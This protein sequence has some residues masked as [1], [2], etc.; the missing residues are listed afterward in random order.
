MFPAIARSLLTS[1]L[2]VGLLVIKSRY[3][4]LYIPRNLAS[5]RQGKQTIFWVR[6]IIQT[7]CATGF[8][9]RDSADVRKFNPSTSLADQ[10]EPTAL[11]AVRVKPSY[12]A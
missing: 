9:Y 2:E 12:V 7:C 3:R 1:R 11:W 6:E 5:T 4:C 10:S 8:H